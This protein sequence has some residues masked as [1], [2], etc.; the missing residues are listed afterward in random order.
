MDK[1]ITDAVD[2]LSSFKSG[3]AVTLTADGR[4][5][6][7]LVSRTARR[8]DGPFGSYE[9]TRITVT[10]GPGRYARE[11]TAEEIATG[12]AGITRTA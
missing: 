9:S 3:E 1:K 6:R 7:M 2:L 5:H 4:E 10:F 8:C 12:K 11:V